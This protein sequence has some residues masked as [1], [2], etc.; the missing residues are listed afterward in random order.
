MTGFLG[1][2]G[3]GKTTTLRMLL[4]LVHA[5]RRHRD[6]RRRRRYRDLERPLA[7][8]GTALEAS[9]FH[10]GRTARNHLRVYAA[11]GGHPG[12]ARGR[13]ARAHRDRA[14]A[15][16]RRVGGFSMGMRQRLGLAFALLGDPGCS[17][18][19]SRSTGSTPRASAGSADCCSSSPRGTHRAG[20]VAPA[21]R[22]AAERRAGGDHLPRPDRPRGLAR[23]ARGD[24]SVCSWTAPDRD[25]LHARSRLAGHQTVERRGRRRH[26]S[27]TGVRLPATRSGA[28]VLARRDPRS[29]LLGAASARGARGRA[30]SDARRRPA[31]EGMG[32]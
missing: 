25:A 27:V 16:D 11:A 24:V 32:A 30:S 28:I 8:V 1:P 20:V 5:D 7:T 29:A 2:N 3:A 23:R 9:S 15:A 6:V 10:P 17:C 4:G 13:G 14:D 31:A 21:E 22:G 26:R 12:H 18:S 19:T